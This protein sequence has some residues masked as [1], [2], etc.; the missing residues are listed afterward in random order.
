[1]SAQGVGMPLISFIIPYYNLKFQLLKE[2]LES[3]LA[4]TLNNKE[5]EIIVVD[6]GS[7]DCFLENVKQIDERI[8]YIKQPNGGLS[9]ARNTGMRFA[10]GKYIQFV[11]G[12]DRL[13]AVPYNHCLALIRTGRP[14]MVLF[15]FA[16]EN[17][18]HTPYKQYDTVTGAYVMRH[19]NIKASACTYIFRREAAGELSF[20]CGIYHE[21]EE[22]TP[23]LL[24]RC[25]KVIMTD[26]GAYYYR[27]REDSIMNSGKR[28]TM[29]KRLND[30]KWIL[31]RL[32][33][34]CDSLPI[35][36]KSAL[37]RRVAQLTMDYIYNVIILTQSRSRLHKE[38]VFLEKIGLYPLPIKNYTIKYKMFSILTAC[39]RVL[40]LSFIICLLHKV[41]M[42]R[43][44]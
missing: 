10:R 9:E 15:N 17:V 27:Q 31:Q 40:F 4:L 11:D 5:K 20:T 36:K 39:K 14:D 24:L 1:M 37:Q 23:L 29:I 42:K 3:I 32:N 34:V 28:K 44:I 16:N 18:P 35:E 41:K 33:S 12:D 25:E 2:C 8:I 38:I 22:F 26:I 21:D 6:D 13:L 19:N 43:P 7:K 30:C